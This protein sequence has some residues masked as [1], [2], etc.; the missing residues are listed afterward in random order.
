[1]LAVVTQRQRLQITTPLVA[2]VLADEMGLGKT[3]QALTAPWKVKRSRPDL[4]SYP[5]R[6]SPNSLLQPPCIGLG[7][8]L[9]PKPGFGRSVRC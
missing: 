3:I 6:P 7:H 1:M 9:L 2:G 5:P 8:R 4:F